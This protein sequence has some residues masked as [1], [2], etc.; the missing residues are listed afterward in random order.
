MEWL[1]QQTWF[2]VGANLLQWL[3]SIGLLAG[4]WHVW[5]HRCHVRFCLRPGQIAVKG[6][7]WK[8]CPKHSIHLHHNKLQEEHRKLHADRIVH[9]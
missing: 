9:P 1:G 2:A 7:T 8:V 4:A 3:S 5:H 6:T